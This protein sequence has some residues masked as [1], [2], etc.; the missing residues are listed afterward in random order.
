MKIQI[1]ISTLIFQRAPAEEKHGKS[2]HWQFE[3]EFQLSR[4]TSFSTSILYIVWD[5][6]FLKYVISPKKYDIEKIE[7]NWNRSVEI[8]LRSNLCPGKTT[9]SY[10]E[11]SGGGGGWRSNLL[12]SRSNLLQTLVAMV[13]EYQISKFSSLYLIVFSCVFS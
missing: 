3:L 6:F 5:A 8:F 11:I 12:W 13:F 4:F 7:K 2:Q 9:S 10:T 1:R